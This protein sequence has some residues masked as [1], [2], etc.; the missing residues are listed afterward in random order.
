MPNIKHIWLFGTFVKS[1]LFEFHLNFKWRMTR[2]GWT[3]WRSCGWLKIGEGRWSAAKQLSFGDYSRSTL[4]VQWP[5]NR[6][7]LGGL[8]SMRTTG[9]WELSWIFVGITKIPNSDIKAWCDSTI[10]IP[11]RS[12]CRYRNHSHCLRVLSCAVPYSLCLALPVGPSN[13]CRTHASDLLT[14]N[15]LQLWCKEEPPPRRLQPPP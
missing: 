15:H 8:L 11:C 7:N 14:L 13:H 10:A 2:G 3:W 1:Y 6:W 5:I 12:Y 4:V 9:S